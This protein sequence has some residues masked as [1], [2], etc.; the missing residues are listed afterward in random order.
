MEDLGISN[1]TFDSHSCLVTAMSKQPLPQFNPPKQG[2]NVSSS[3][4]KRF[5]NVVLVLGLLLFAYGYYT[6]SQV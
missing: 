2:G 5:I 1:F 6:P 4:A 3:Y